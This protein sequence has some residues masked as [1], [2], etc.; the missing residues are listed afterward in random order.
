[1]AYNPAFERQ[2]EVSLSAA[3]HALQNNLNRIDPEKN[4]TLWNQTRANIGICEA[5][6]KT[7]REMEFIQ[8][9]MDAILRIL[10]DNY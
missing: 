4:P 1:M 2:K 10:K 9:K 7:H 8:I 6:D 3:K 5:I